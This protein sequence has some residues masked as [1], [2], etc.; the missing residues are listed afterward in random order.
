MAEHGTLKFH[1]RLA[2]R[3]SNALCGYE[4]APWVLFKEFALLAPST[5][6]V[7]CGSLQNEKAW[8]LKSESNR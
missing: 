6:C 1:I 2:A 4:S 3:D 8:N 7:E 5:V